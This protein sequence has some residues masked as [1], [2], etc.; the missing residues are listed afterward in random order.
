MTLSVVMVLDTK[1]K[2]RATEEKN[3]LCIVKVNTSV[4]KQSVRE[5]EGEL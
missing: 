2:V 4:L 5:W 3:N 1:Q